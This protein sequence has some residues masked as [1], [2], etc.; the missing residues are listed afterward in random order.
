MQDFLKLTEWRLRLMRKPLL[1]VVLLMG[2]AEFLAILADMFLFSE[3]FYAPLSVYFFAA[4]VVLVF[5]MVAAV[6]L[7]FFSVFKQ[8]HHTNFTHSLM[9]LP[10]QRS[11]LYWSGVASG[12]LSVWFIAAAQVVWYLVLYVPVNFCSNFYTVHTAQNMLSNSLLTEMPVGSAFLAN[13][14]WNTMMHTPAM[15]MLFPRN[16][17]TLLLVLVLIAAP[18]CCLHAISCHRGPSRTASTVLLVV[19][20]LLSLVGSRLLYLSVTNLYHPWGDVVHLRNILILQLVLIAAVSWWGI[21]SL[22]RS[23]NL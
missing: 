8:N 19:S 7:S 18:V 4:A 21:H 20:A 1:W 16:L 6:L 23:E 5:C 12:L 9:L 3:R 15:Q 22:N 14:L 17:P 2:P 11:T 10:V 13:G